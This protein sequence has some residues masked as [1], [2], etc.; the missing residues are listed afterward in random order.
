MHPAIPEKLLVE[1]RD[2]V[3]EPIKRLFTPMES[4]TEI[5]FE[6]GFLPEIACHEM[7][8]REYDLVIAGDYRCHT[9]LALRFHSISREIVRCASCPVL[10]VK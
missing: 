5:R 9:F 1:C 7:M 8:E 6:F 2:K 4:I 10:I 3:L